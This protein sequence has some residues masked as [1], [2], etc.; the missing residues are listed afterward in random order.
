M[1]TR[2]TPWPEGT[3]SWVDLAVP[4]RDAAMEF[5][6][7]VLD[8]EFVVHGP[9][10]GNYAIATVDGRAAAGIGPTPPGAEGV[11]PAWTTYLAS[12]DVDATCQTITASGGSVIF[13]PG[14]VGEQGRMAIAADPTGGV[15]GVWQAGTTFGAAVVNQPGALVWNELLSRDA[16]VARQFYAAVFGYGYTSVEDSGDYTTIDGEGPGGVIGGIGQLPADAP[17]QVPSHW[18][19]YFSVA[20]IDD[21]A[22]RVTAAG[23]TLQ[24]PTRDTPYGRFAPC[25]DPY[26]A[27]FTLASGSDPE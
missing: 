1:S 26:G 23:G 11:P 24:E 2:D 27:A 18:K 10:Y 6:R 19:A 20:D 15:F 4:D 25:Q 14:D 12:D 9:E 21:A 22:K 17:A 3:P 16:T 8:W 5:Y 7:Q 13:G